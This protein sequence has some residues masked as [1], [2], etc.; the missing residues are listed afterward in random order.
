[1]NDE[2]VWKLA[3]DCLHEG[4]SAALLIVV[5]SHGGSPGRAGFK[6]AVANDGRLAGTI[7]GGAVEHGF[8]EKARERLRR[9]NPAPLL[10]RQNHDQGAIA[11]Q[12]GMNCGGG[13]TIALYPC[14]KSDLATIERL[15]K[16]AKGHGEGILR[17]SPSDLSFLPGRRNS[18]NH[19]FQWEAGN[20]RY[21][22]NI[23][24]RHTAYLIGGGHVGQA[25]SRVLAMLDFHIVVLDERPDIGAFGDGAHAHEKITISY[26]EIKQYVPDG[27]RNYAVIMTPDHKADKRVLERLLDKKIRYLGMMGS[28]RKVDEVFGQ[29][30]DEGIAPKRLQHVH[31]PIGLP[32]G[33]HTPAE[34]AVSIAAEMISVIRCIDLANLRLRR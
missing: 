28:A 19:H 4:I 13:Q 29:L 24:L 30:R 31:A 12:S 3:G 22:E 8:V 23:G 16:S 27:E 21:E 9:G 5:E 32:I 20:W 2:N 33:S 17:L 10:R 18:D 11:D 26:Q 6:M 1:M 34:I 15:T 25:L 7:G 14:R